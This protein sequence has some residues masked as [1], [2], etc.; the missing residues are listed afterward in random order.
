MS[1]FLVVASYQIGARCIQTYVRRPNNYVRCKTYWSPT[2]ISLQRI[3]RL[4]RPEEVTPLTDGRIGWS[5]I[6]RQE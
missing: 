6:P 5:A 4:M 1:D 2:A 3:A